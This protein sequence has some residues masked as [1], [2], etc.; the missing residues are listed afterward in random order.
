MAKKY[1]HKLTDLEVKN[2]IDGKKKFG[3]LFEHYKAPKWCGHANPI[4]P[5]CIGCEILMNDRKK[6]SPSYCAAYC[7]HFKK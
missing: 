1:W 7:S 5:G 3:Y 4:M 2:I 6:I